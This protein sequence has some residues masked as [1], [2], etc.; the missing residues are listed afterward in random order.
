[1]WATLVLLDEPARAREAAARAKL[2]VSTAGRHIGEEA[3]QLP[4]GIGMTAEYS[5]GHYMSRLTAI[6]HWLG[7]GQEH[8]RAL[9]DTLDDHT[10]LNPLP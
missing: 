8:L 4:G 5:V 2:Q 3:I 10:V 9:A 7:D 6:D 1:M